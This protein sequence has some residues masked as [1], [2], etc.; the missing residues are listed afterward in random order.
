MVKRLDP[1]ALKREFISR[2]GYWNRVWDQLLTEDPSFFAA[3]SGFSSIPID[4]AALDIKTQE[5]IFIAIDASTT[6]LYEPGIRIHMR[7]A[8][9]AGATKREILEVLELVSVIGIHSVTVGLPL[10]LAEVER[11]EV[12]DNT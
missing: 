7:N 6:H 11:T 1:D 5:L 4:S 3:Y 12:S 10:L 9:A 8:L 2:R